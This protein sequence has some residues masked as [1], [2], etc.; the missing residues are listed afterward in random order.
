MSGL[1]QI[2]MAKGCDIIAVGG[3]TSVR[4]AAALMHR[5]RVGCVVVED[6]HDPVGV[7]S[8]RDLVRV[9]A[10]GR[11]PD[12]TAVSEVMSAPPKTCRVTDDVEQCARRMSDE[13]V[14]H[15][16]VLDDDEPIGMVSMRDLLEARLAP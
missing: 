14:R 16:I 7:F 11:D 6:R 13:K 3:A 15:L 10:S 1:G 5:H 2:L 9:I 12:A 4:R 8:E